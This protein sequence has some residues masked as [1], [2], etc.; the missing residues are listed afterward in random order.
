MSAAFSCVPE[1]SKPRAAIFGWAGPMLAPDERAFLRT[2]DPLGCILFQRN[3]VEP[4]QLRRLVVDLR[5][6][7]GRSDAPVLIDQEGGRV[8]R[9]RPPHWRTYPAAA[10]IAALGAEAPAAARAVARLIPDDLDCLRIPLH[11]PPVLHLPGPGAHARIGHPP[12]ATDP[13]P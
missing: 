6:S 12:H 10:R 11:C 5:D 1:M 2:E 9:L 4:E 8:A 3:C 13:V 7:I